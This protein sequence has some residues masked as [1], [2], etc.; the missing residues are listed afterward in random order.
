MVNVLL[1]VLKE[2]SSQLLVEYQLV[3]LVDQNVMYVLLQP[4]VLLASNP[5]MLSEALVLDALLVITMTVT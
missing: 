1:H 4:L 3:S 2:L 5:M